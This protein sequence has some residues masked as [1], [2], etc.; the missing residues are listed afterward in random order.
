MLTPT[1]FEI[2][3][4]AEKTKPDAE[5]PDFAFEGGQ[6]VSVIVPGAGPGGRD[7]RRA[8][9]IASSPET[10]PVE[11]CIKLVED[12]P[13]TNYLYKLRA[14][15]AFRGV[16]PYGDFTYVPRVGRRACMVATG[17]GI[18]PFRAMVFSKDYGAR[19]PASA[20]C[21]MGVRSEDELIYQA[22]MSAVPGLTW[23]SA[24]TQPRGE[25]AGFRGRVTDWLRAQGDSFPWLETDFYLCGNGAMIKE[26]KE[27]LAEKGVQKDAIHQEKYY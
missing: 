5:Q 10:R 18:A 16:A 20:W 24:V 22:E 27:L 12:G 11:L 25:F 2:A 26:M 1:V 15:D 17:T 21:L 14:G 8:Y 4:E 23:V 9:S 19:P 6:F 13:G 3:F 7:L